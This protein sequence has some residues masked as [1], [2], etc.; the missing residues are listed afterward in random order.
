VACGEVEPEF[1][2]AVE[3][4]GT[5]GS[6]E[7]LPILIT[8]KSCQSGRIEVPAAIKAEITATSKVLHY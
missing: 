1:V 3:G 4:R 2:R 5:A 6:I 7:T 8:P